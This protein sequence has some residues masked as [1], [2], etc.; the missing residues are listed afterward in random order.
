M[1]LV[2]GERVCPERLQ[3]RLAKLSC[4]TCP[5]LRASTFQ[6]LKSE[7]RH[8]RFR[9]GG[10]TLGQKVEKKEISVKFNSLFRLFPSFE[11]GIRNSLMEARIDIITFGKEG[12][13]EEH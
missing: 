13:E 10:V 3:L 1:S 8:V 11:I 6:P 5:P 9:S 7:R 2:P 12:R 4:Q